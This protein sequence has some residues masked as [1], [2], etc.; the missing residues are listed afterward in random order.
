VHFK[1]ESSAVKH[2]QV[3]PLA[4]LSTDSVLKAEIKSLSALAFLA[5]TLCR[6]LV[7]RPVCAEGYLLHIVYLCLLLVRTQRDS[8]WL[9]LQDIKQLG[10]AVYTF[11]EFMAL[12]AAHP[13]AAEP[14]SA[15]D[16]CTVRNHHL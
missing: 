6:T 5:S 3:Q 4:A 16:V 14:P 7:A 12:G 9:C 15:E 8:Q 11:Q 1:V 2:F 13:A 10:V